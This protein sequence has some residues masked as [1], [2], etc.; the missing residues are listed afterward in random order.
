MFAKGYLVRSERARLAEAAP[1]G[2][3]KVILRGRPN[4]TNQKAV[5]ANHKWTRI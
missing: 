5:R 3:K 4:V 2:P 1:Q